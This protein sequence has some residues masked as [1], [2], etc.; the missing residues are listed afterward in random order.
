MR[1]AL[2]VTAVLAAV[3]L[4]GCSPQRIDDLLISCP[5]LTLPADVADLTRYT[6]GSPPDLSALVLDARITAVDGRCK[7]GRGDATVDAEL[8][9]R[10]QMDRGP[11]ATTRAAQLPWFIAVLDAE[12]DQVVN[13]MSFVLPAQFGANSSRGV[14][15]SRPVDISFPVGQ[16]RRAQDYKIMVGFQLTPEELALNRRRGPR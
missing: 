7:R 3:G 13:R 6:P 15:S 4:S 11:A 12:T 14:V 5:T 9:V 8:S 10:F 16:G 2:G 1:L